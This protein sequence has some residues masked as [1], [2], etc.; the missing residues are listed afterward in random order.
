MAHETHLFLRAPF[1]SYDLDIRTFQTRRIIWITLYP[2]NLDRN[3][4]K[5]SELIIQFTGTNKYFQKFEIV[6]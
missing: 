1:Y 3:R 5:T 2:F 4:H 6:S